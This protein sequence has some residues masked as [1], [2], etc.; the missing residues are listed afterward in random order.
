M[1]WNKVNWSKVYL[2]GWGGYPKHANSIATT[3]SLYRKFALAK[4]KDC[5]KVFAQ[6]SR[7]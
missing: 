3:I 4:A 1:K 7:F 5:T 6:C 2:T